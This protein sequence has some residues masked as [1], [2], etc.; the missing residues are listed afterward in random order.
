MFVL[1]WD[2]QHTRPLKKS[3]EKN[4]KFLPCKTIFWN[5]LTME[6]TVWDGSETI[7]PGVCCI[8]TSHDSFLSLKSPPQTL[9]FLTFICCLLTQICLDSDRRQIL[10]FS[11]QICLD[12][13]G[14]PKS[15]GSISLDSQVSGWGVAPQNMWGLLEY[16]LCVNGFQLLSLI[17][18]MWIKTQGSILQRTVQ[19]PCVI[20]VCLW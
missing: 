2:L 17:T 15:A 20:L 16:I 14:S 10:F 6:N 11:D 7:I 8:S 12:S 1:F 3:Q 9:F 5:E 4:P 19:I 13:L 18:L